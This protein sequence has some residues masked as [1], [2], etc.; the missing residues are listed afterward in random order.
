MNSRELNP[1]IKHEYM[2]MFGDVVV[3]E[4]TE[5]GQMITPPSATDPAKQAKISEMYAMSAALGGGK[6]L[7]EKKARAKYGSSVKA[8]KRNV[9]ARDTEPE[10]LTP[11]ITQ[12]E[13]DNEPELIHTSGYLQVIPNSTKYFVYLHNKLGK[14]KLKVDAVLDSE[15]AYCLVFRSEDDVIFTPNAGETLQFTDIRGDTSSVYY[16]DT[17]FNWID[18]TKKLMIL[19]KSNKNE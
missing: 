19:F 4:Y 7:P 17:L 3:G 15:M 2:K 12:A 1:N 10:P 18:G 9:K 14:I 5:N 13:V 11:A 8:G 6:L 16:A